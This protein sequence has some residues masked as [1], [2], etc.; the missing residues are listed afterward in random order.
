MARVPTSSL[1]GD[2]LAATPREEWTTSNVVAKAFLTCP[3]LHYINRL[4]CWRGGIDESRHEDV[5]QNAWIAIMSP[6]ENGVPKLLLL[7]DEK[8]GIYSYMWQFIFYTV[9]TLRHKDRD[10]DGSKFSLSASDD[11]QD[12]DPEKGEKYIS[13]SDYGVLPNIDEE[14]IDRVD[15]ERAVLRW[16][17]KIAS[18]G[19]PA[20]V[21]KGVDHFVRLG[22][23]RKIDQKP[24]PPEV[25]EEFGDAPPF[26]A[27]LLAI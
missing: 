6:S 23:P 8:D 13:H 21:P 25:K 16:Q 20:H 15:R 26:L 3:R 11:H 18:Q 12:E 4:L 17:A 1:L 14:V 10:N 22:R 19:W 24:A 5:L 9:R 27:H 2:A 7:D